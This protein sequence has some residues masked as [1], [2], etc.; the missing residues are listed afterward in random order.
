MCIFN[1]V[2][3]I[4]KPGPAVLKLC[5]TPGGKVIKNPDQH[6][7]LYYYFENNQKVQ[8]FPLSEDVIRL[9]EGIR[10]Y[11]YPISMTP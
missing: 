3:S 8:M 4:R 1:P 2:S 11:K 5:L 7:D 9:R 10:F 6:D